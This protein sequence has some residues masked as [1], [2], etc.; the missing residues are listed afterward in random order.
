M[1]DYRNLFPAITPH[2]HLVIPNHVTLIHFV[3][4]GSG[5]PL[6]KCFSSPIYHDCGKGKH[7]GST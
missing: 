2:F 1:L 7:V 5:S 6:Q 3:I 4:I